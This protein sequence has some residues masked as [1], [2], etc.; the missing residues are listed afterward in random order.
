MFGLLT[1]IFNIVRFLAVLF[2]VGWVFIF[3]IWKAMKL[4]YC[5]KCQDVIRLIE[6]RRYCRCGSISGKYIDSLQ[7]E[8]SGACAIPIGF[9]NSDFLRAMR[10]QP[11]SGLGEHFEA[12]VIP[13]NCETFVMRD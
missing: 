2:A 3:R 13:R 9:S 5:Q 4:L 11:D 6:A 1:D 12:F 8:Y 7:A 10:N